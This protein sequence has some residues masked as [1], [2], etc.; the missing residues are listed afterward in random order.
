MTHE[1]HEQALEM[2][3]NFT[4]DQI[5]EKLGERR[6]TVDT[7]LRSRG[8]TPVT[9]GDQIRYKLYREAANKTREQMF[10]E[11]GVSAPTFDKYVA[12]TGVKFYEKV[13]YRPRVSFWDRLRGVAEKQ[14]VAEYLRTVARKSPGEG[15]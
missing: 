9:K 5:A 4:A 15:A 8:I 11:L 14:S 12:E 3:Q 6:Q 2:A 10:Q 7:F 13:E 1:Q